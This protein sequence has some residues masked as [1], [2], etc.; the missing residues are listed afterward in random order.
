[1][2]IYKWIDSLFDTYEKRSI[3]CNF[4]VL[5]YWIWQ[6]IWQC[7]FMLDLTQVSS[8]EKLF[9]FYSKLSNY[10]NSFLVSTIL[11]IISF[12]KVTFSTVIMSF[13]QNIGFLDIIMCALTLLL[14]L[15]SE[16]KRKW[17]ILPLLYIT[18]FIFIGVCVGL[19]FQV[20][21]LDQ[22]VG[23]LKILSIGSLIIELVIIFTLLR[24]VVMY[25]IEYSNFL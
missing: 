14:F 16:N 8:Y 5:A 17:M 1:M 15:K 20:G 7:V 13:F 19:G 12:N 3:I 18:L 6:N 9:S 25:A 10:A 21:S 22:L 11:T 23:L 2:K 24:K 4:I